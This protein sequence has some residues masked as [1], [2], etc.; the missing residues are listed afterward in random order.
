ME[1]PSDNVGL[2]SWAFPLA[3]ELLKRANQIVAYPITGAAHCALA[4]VWMLIS[5]N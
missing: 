3:T 5:D 4:L 1:S 2:D